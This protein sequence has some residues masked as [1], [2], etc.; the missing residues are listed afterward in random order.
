[1]TQTDVID[2]LNALLAD[3]YLQR[4]LYETYS[5]YLFGLNS[6]A[7]QTHLKEHMDEESG[8]IQILQRYLSHFGAAP[9]I[10]RKEIINL[11]KISLRKILETDLE[12]ELRAVE[13]YSNAI[14][15]LENQT[16]FS[17]VRVALENILIQEQDHVHDLTRWLRDDLCPNCKG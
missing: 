12:L 1:M 5:Y 8:H 14:A 7:I 10:K 2:M 9:A 4:D 6:P 17:S 13:N 3:E 15:L 16:K 11:S